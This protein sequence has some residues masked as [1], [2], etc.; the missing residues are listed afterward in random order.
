MAHSRDQLLTNDP[1]MRSS[2]TEQVWLSETV[3]DSRS[4]DFRQ[5]IEFRKGTSLRSPSEVAL[6]VL[7]RSFSEGTPLAPKLLLMISAMLA[8][9]Q[10]RQ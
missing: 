9:A 7:Y 2:N 1:F 6:N 8:R 10:G 3:L 4:T 5:T